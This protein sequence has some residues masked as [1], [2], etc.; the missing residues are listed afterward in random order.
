MDPPNSELRLSRRVISML[1]PGTTRDSIQ[2]IPMAPRG[3]K[4]KKY[5][6]SEESVDWPLMFSATTMMMTAIGAAT[7]AVTYTSAIISIVLRDISS[8]FSATSL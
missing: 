7:K 4:M 6:M 2:T 1:S 8:S 5:G 3:R